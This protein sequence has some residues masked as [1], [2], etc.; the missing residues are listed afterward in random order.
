MGK[1][2]K[3]ERSGWRDE[4]ISRRHREWGYD[5]PAL[6]LD[7]LV[8]EYDTATPVALVEYK[9]EHARMATT[10][11][12]NY[13]ALI[14]LGDMSGLPVFAVRYASDLSWLRITALNCIAR[15]K[16]T[17]RSQGMTEL[18]Y[19]TLL[20]KLRD[21]EIPIE[22]ARKLSGYEDEKSWTL[23]DSHNYTEIPF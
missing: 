7:W 12:A 17:E 4:T 11:E 9:N 23:P 10:K 13:R 8:I 6:D 3:P 2:V 22:V 15:G 21:R 19:V 1:E 16:V 5:C 20:Y 14:K 18:A